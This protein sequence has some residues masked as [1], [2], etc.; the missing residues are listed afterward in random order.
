[1]R[2]NILGCAP[3][4]RDCPDGNGEIWGVN[5]LFLSRKCDVVVDCHNLSRA[6]KGKEKLGRRNP[7]E[8]RA[9]LKGLKKQEI[10]VYTT[11]RIKNIPNSIEYPL[12]EI[13]SEISNGHDYFASGVDYAIAL[14]IYKG[15]TEIHL[16]G[17]LMMIQYEYAHQKSSAEHWLGIAIGRGVKVRVHGK[18]AS[19]LKTRNHMLY[20][21]GT[22]QAHVSEQHPEY[23]I[24][25]GEI[26]KIEAQA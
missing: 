13:I 16:W 26:K 20:G 17:V 21:Y 3:G 7:D 23:I 9:C 19:L 14:A 8:V 10:P 22:P 18:L 1:M 12:K 25:Q 11:R 24:Q 6:A 15:A 5:D 2:I 4:W